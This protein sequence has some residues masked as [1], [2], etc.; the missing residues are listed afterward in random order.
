[1]TP[2]QANISLQSYHNRSVRHPHS[3]QLLGG[4]NLD[5]IRQHCSGVENGITSL[6][7]NVDMILSVF[8]HDLLCSC[9]HYIFNH[10]E[11]THTS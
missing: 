11:E 9:Q 10:F 4:L 8:V 7:V 3:R 5:K 6:N 2:A 1:M